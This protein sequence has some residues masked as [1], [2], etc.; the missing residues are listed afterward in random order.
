MLESVGSTPS[1]IRR[2]AAL[3]GREYECCNKEASRV[4]ADGQQMGT[5]GRW[6]QVVR[7]AA[8]HM[9]QQS[10]LPATLIA[11]NSEC[12]NIYTVAAYSPAPLP[13]NRVRVK[14]SSFL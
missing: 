10:L 4:C 11:I 7:N 3:P 2:L 9:T 1:L 13:L 6:P 14:A 12:S 8:M 5:K